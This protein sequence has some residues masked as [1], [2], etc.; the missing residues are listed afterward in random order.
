MNMQNCYWGYGDKYSMQPRNWPTHLRRCSEKLQGVS[1]TCEDFEQVIAQAPIMLFFLS[2]LLISM[3]TRINSTLTASH[4]RIITAWH[5]YYISIVIGSVFYLLMTTILGYE[6]SS[7][8]VGKY[9]IE[10]GI[11]PLTV[12]MT[13]PERLLRKGSGIW[14]KRCLS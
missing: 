3:L 9:W 11:T 6:N 14:G 4:Y 10:N 13:R 7:I 12:P 2:T 5:V 1:I 8:G